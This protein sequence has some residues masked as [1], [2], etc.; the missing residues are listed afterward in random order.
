MVCYAKITKGSVDKIRENMIDEHNGYYAH[1]QTYPTKV[2]YSRDDSLES[3]RWTSSG[4]NELIV[5]E[6]LKG[7]NTITVVYEG[8]RAAFGDMCRFLEQEPARYDWVIT[9]SCHRNT[10]DGRVAVRPLRSTIIS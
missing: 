1:H 3:F 7:S 4:G 9:Q 8:R 6:P 2:G 10:P 5:F